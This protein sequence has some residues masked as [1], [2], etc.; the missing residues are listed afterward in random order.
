MK[1]QAQTAQ[2]FIST[3]FPPAFAGVPLADCVGAVVCS[4]EGLEPEAGADDCALWS[5]TTGPELP[6]PPEVVLEGPAAAAGLFAPWE[7]PCR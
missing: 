2:V 4:V 6:E 1:E 7:I 3:E 5:L